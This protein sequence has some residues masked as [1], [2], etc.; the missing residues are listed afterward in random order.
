MTGYLWRFYCLIFWHFASVCT[1]TRKFL[2]NVMTCAKRLAWQIRISYRDF[3]RSKIYKFSKILSFLDHFFCQNNYQKVA[4]V[5]TCAC[6]FN[7]GD[8]PF[9]SQSGL[10]LTRRHS[11]LWSFCF[12]WSTTGLARSGCHFYNNLFF[13]HGQ[14]F[15]LAGLF[16]RFI[17]QFIILIFILFFSNFSFFFWIF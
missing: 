6:A 17:F 14:V 12:R 3:C 11:A 9:L 10:V 1:S 4:R 5:I 7:W 8:N 15:D 13:S 2:T 16:S